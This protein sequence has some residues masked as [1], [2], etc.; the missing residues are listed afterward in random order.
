LLEISN[1]ESSFL[2]N[3]AVEKKRWVSPSTVDFIELFVASMASFVA[4]VND[5]NR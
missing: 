3:G 5:E 2:T 1:L 4:V